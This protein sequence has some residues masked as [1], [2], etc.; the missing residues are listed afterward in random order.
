RRMLGRRPGFLEQRGLENTDLAIGHEEHAVRLPVEI[1]K[2]LAD[3]QRRLLLATLDQ[4]ANRAQIR[5]IHAGVHGKQQVGP[6]RRLQLSEKAADRAEGSAA[7]SAPSH[8]DLELADVD[9]A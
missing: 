6:F 7:L 1:A 2:I 9:A 4:E 3:V 5:L 8:P